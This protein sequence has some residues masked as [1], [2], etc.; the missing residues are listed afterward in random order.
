MM[1]KMAFLA[2]ILGGFLLP[3]SAGADDGLL[4]A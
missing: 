3:L 4:E 2:A 1:R